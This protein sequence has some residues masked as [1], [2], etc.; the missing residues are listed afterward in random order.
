MDDIL[1]GYAAAA[2]P[3]LIA[4]Y[5]ELDVEEIY[6]PVL[7]L[8]PTA[9]VRVCDIGTGTG[10]DAA[11]FAALGHQV[12]AVEPVAELREAGIALHPSGRITWLDD[13][14]PHLDKTTQHG[15]FDLVTL[16]GVWQHL[17][18]DAR[19]IAVANLA[20]ITAPG[21][22]L[23]M[24]LRHGPGAAGRRVFPIEP[25]ETI[26]AACGNGFSLLRRVETGS[27]QPGKIAAGVRW[28]WV[29]LR[30]S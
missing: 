20:E 2:T 3:S 16:C 21:G 5:D 10:R 29:A 30:K 14:L 11:W 17:E 26:A 7:D 24:S 4:R 13:R 1:Q 23:V 28:T 22:M 8:L 9:P 6:A 12:L 18:E 25:H 27:I 15:R 19:D